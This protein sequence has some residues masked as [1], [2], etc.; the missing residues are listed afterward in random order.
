[1]DSISI[2]STYCK[3]SKERKANMRARYI[4]RRTFRQNVL[5]KYYAGEGKIEERILVFYGPQD[6][7]RIN[8]HVNRECSKCHQ[9][10]LEKQ[11]I[12]CQRVKVRMLE[13]DFYQYSEIVNCEEE[14][15]E[16]D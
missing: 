10:P 1:M 2:I 14:D 12:D 6:A 4:T 9:I 16:N 5:V 3:S 13:E 15:A 8:E 7:E 11:I